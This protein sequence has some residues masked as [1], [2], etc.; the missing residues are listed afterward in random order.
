MIKTH[1]LRLI[2]SVTGRS[3][4]VGLI[5]G[6]FR[7]LLG[8]TPD[9][10]IRLRGSCCPRR[11]RDS[12]GRYQNGMTDH[13][14]RHERVTSSS[15]RKGNGPHQTEGLQHIMAHGDIRNVTKRTYF[16][17]EH[18]IPTKNNAFP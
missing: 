5:F 7:L 18:K 17:V 12:C 16:V 3:L 15:R 10:N 8:R 14:D 9:K 6:T 4:L 11:Y 13:A 2:R 1:Q